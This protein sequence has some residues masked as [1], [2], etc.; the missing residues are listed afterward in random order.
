MKKFIQRGLYFTLFVGG[1]SCL[2]VAAANAA[3]TTSGEDGL[4]SGTQAVIGLEV[5]VDLSGNA[6]SILGDATTTAPEAAPAAEPAPAP[7][8]APEPVAEAT[9]SGEDGVASGTQAVVDVDVPIDVSG[10]AISVVGDS[11][12]SGAT[13]SAP[14]ASEAP[15][16]DAPAATTTGSDSLLGGTQGPVDVDIPITVGG[17]AIT[18]IGDSSSSG[19]TSTAGEPSDSPAGTGASTS[20]E[21]GI[22]GGTQVVGDIGAP[23]T[24]GGNAITVIG[25]AESTDS[26]TTGGTTGGTGTTGSGA[27]T[28]GEDGILGG[29]QIVPVIGAPVTVGGNAI[30]VI[31]DAESTDS[32]TTGGTTGGT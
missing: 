30:T 24:V 29:T 15:A 31:G 26:S 21:D 9:T 1:L 3:D 22:L 2:G 23:V 32:S 25:D 19:S 17:N 20:G 8:P 10:N 14:A 6:I 18:V 28:S 11:E 13:E 5:P 27:T 4:V 7:E 16:E 12:Q